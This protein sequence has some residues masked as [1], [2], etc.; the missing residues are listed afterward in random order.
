MKFKRIHSV[1][2]KGFTL[3]EL[4][5]VI[6][7]IAIL[8]AMLLPALS[9]AKKKATMA[10]C[11][12][13]FRQEHLALTM[14]VGENNDFLPP[15][16]GAQTGIQS[17]QFAGYMKGWNWFLVTHLSG[18]LGYPEP[19]A[20]VT[21]VA[22]VMICPGFTRNANNA[23]PAMIVSYNLDG[24]TSDVQLP[25]WQYPH[26]IDILPFGWP[27]LGTPYGIDLTT[28]C[29]PHKITEVASKA[30]PTSIWYICDS[31]KPGTV[32]AN[33]T[34]SQI[35]YMPVTPVHGSRRNYVYFDGHVA[36]QKILPSGSYNYNP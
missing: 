34:S 2:S 32:A 19:S 15:G 27:S 25:N 11:M 3:I 9:A 30:P 10:G 23:D 13:N 17:G 20:T 5:V 12:S 36:S 22:K 7:I 31:D 1:L 4:L 8:A 35:P 16:E 6:A 33:P 29:G 24:H 26:G 14:F 28:Y 18:Y 21:N